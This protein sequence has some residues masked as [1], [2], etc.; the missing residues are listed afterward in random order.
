[1][2]LQPFLTMYA[3]THDAGNSELVPT[4]AERAGGPFTAFMRALGGKTFNGVYRVHRWDR[5]EEYTR[6]IEAMYPALKGE[7]VAF[8]SDW[9]G[10]QFAF[11]FT[12]PAAD[13]PGVTWF[14]LGGADRMPTDQNIADFHNVTLIERANDTLSLGLYVE[15]RAADA[16]E[17]PPGQCV[18]YK[19]PLF[20]G[21]NDDVSN[22][23]R[24]DTPTYLQ[25]CARMWADLTV[26]SKHTP[27]ENPFDE[28][29]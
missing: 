23:H 19:V 7:L 1:M 24:I 17:I 6:L 28:I 3:V 10:R 9:T 8:A 5:V 25:H 21:S 14:D 2:N 13:Q 20:M 22:L 11:D 16:R 18:G 4:V 12:E 29:T 15:W 26:I 27:G